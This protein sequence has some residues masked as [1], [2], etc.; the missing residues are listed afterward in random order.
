MNARSLSPA[1]SAD[2][3][4]GVMRAELFE[5]EAAAKQFLLEKLIARATADGTALESQELRVLM[6]SA[7]SP[8]PRPL[9]LNEESDEEFTDRSAGILLRSY[10]HDTGAG[11]EACR[12]AV[13][14]LARGDDYL[15]VVAYEAG[16]RAPLPRWRARFRRL[17]FLTLLLAP[18][19]FAGLFGAVLVRG[20]VAQPELGPPRL[21]I[22]AGGLAFC[23]AGAYLLK[24]WWRERR[25]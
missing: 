16:I 10:S 6:Q 23:G 9:P 8:E 19:A 12:R 3:G 18:G 25:E 20:A 13:E 17:G 4:V 14:R 22:G 7:D 5:S 21:A 24:L 1:C 11:R 15:S 2:L